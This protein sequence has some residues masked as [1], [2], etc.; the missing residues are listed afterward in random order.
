MFGA[1]P[2]QQ[3]IHLGTFFARRSHSSSKEQKKSKLDSA[4]WLRTE[5]HHSSKLVQ[6]LALSNCRHA[7]V[8]LRRTFHRTHLVIHS[9]TT[10]LT[11]TSWTSFSLTTPT[12]N[13]LDL[14]AYGRTE[15]STSLDFAACGRT[16][17]SKSPDLA[18]GRQIRLVGP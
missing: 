7:V 15:T 11:I 13:S 2:L 10:L 18:Y 3:L 9:S 5:T 16:E 14:P 17:T 12:P 6:L 1:C 4:T 8:R